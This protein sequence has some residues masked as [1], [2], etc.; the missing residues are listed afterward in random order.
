MHWLPF[1][2]AYA[3]LVV[4]GVAVVARTV[5]WARMPLHMRWELYPV[6]HEPG[7]ASYGGSYMEETEWW[8]KPR[9]VSLLGELKVMVPEILFLVALREKNP[10]LWMRSFPFHFGLYLVTVCTVLLFAGGALEAALGSGAEG[11]GL[12]AVLG[13]AALWS[14]RIGAL[15]VLLGAVGLLQRRLG[16]HELRDYGAPMDAL[17]LVIFCVVFALAL[18]VAWGGDP[19]FAAT[20]AFVRDLLLFAPGGGGA[21]AAGG[22]L[23]TTTIVLL[24]ALVAYIP[25]THMSHFV[26]KYFAYHAIRWADEPNLPGGRLEKRIGEVLQRP[27]SWPAAHIGG[28]GKKSW[29]EAATEDQ[30]QEQ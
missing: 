25:L 10:G 8:T 22:A 11:S 19:G 7:R 6:A 24:S 20:R 15:L 1:V 2:A 23:V 5:M 13:G 27:I 29:A 14:G 12:L 16:T 21:A 9:A 26:G 3:G 4:F 28:D 30:E 17:N 18:A